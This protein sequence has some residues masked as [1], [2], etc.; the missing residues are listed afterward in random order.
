M[1]RPI[2]RMSGVGQC[3][4]ALSAQRQG[5]KP[6]GVPPWL[7]TAAEEGKWHEKRII[8]EL[9]NNGEDVYGFQEEV[10]LEFP[11]FILVGHIDGKNTEHTGGDNV[12]GIHRLLEIKSMSQFEFDRWMK[13]GW[14]GFSSY[15]DQVTCYMEA[16]GLKECRYIVKNRSSG[17]KDDKIVAGQPGDINAIIKKMTDIE[18]WLAK[19]IEPGARDGVYPAEFNPNNLE[20]RR[21]FFKYL[22]APEQ[23]E[24]SPME[25]ADLE[26]ASEEWR[27]GTRLIAQGKELV[28]I[29]KQSFAQHTKATGIDKWRFAELAITLVRVNGSLIYPKKKLLEVFS[30]EELAEVAEIKVPYEFIKVTDFRKEEEGR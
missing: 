5:Y 12:P 14:S 22:C 24:L 6:E 19:N 16:T 21:C 10:T 25:Q 20:C 8:E 11:T 29:A 30:E 1:N 23:K 9:Q 28:D 13:E 27:K 15:A 3:A 7:E 4:R 26:S 17:Y 2:Y 18:D